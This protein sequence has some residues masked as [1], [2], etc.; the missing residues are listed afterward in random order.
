MSRAAELPKIPVIDVG[1]DGARAVLAAEPARAEAL[2][3]SAARTY[4]RPVLRLGDALSR[5]WLERH[6]NPHLAEIDAIAAALETPGA[7]FL[8]VSYEWGCTGGVTSAPG[9]GCRLVRVLDWPFD[10][11]GANLIAARQDGPAGDWI[12]LTWPGFAGCIQGQAPG[13][14]AAA[15]NQAPMTRYSPLMPLDWA[16]DRGRLWR[17]G[18]LPPAHL[19]RQVFETCPDYRAARKALCGTPL[20][21]P[22]IFL[23]AGPGPGQGCL[24]ERLETRATVFEQPAVAANH[25]Q[26]PG[27][28]GRPRGNDSQGRRR[29]LAARLA[30]AGPEL[31]WLAPPVLNATTR[32]AMVAEPANGRLTVRGFEAHGPA[33]ATL[34]LGAPADSRR[35]APESAAKPLEIH[36]ENR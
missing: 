32:L 24:I 25:W 13:R 28:R 35:A 20:A 21:R 26:T 27:W 29:N 8:N 14:F 2:L 15:L 30:G 36:G 7:H 11:L 23:L 1:A 18:G 3:A 9:G 17:H 12:N 16:I 22:A 34:R 10:G 33:T 5:R 6:G 31:D 19:L 4:T